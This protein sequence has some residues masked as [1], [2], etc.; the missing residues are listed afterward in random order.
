MIGDGRTAALV[1]REGSIDWLCLP[2]F[3]SDACCAALLGTARHGAWRIA[4]AGDFTSRRQY[5]DHTLVLCTEFASGSARVRL[6]DFMDVT[7][8]HPTVVR[9]LHGV[10]GTMRMRCIMAPRFDYG[11]VPPRIVPR[12]GAMLAVIGPDL[13][14]L[15]APVAFS[16]PEPGSVSAEFDIAAG[17]S[18]AFVLSYGLSHLP[19]PAAVEP[20]DALARTLKFWR[21]WAGQ[22]HFETAW[23]EPV[24][25]SLLTLKALVYRPTGGMV[26]AATASL[27]EVPAGTAN[28]DYRYSWLRDATFT[29]SALLNAGYH[30]EARSWR[31]W[32]LR[33]I[34]E[35]PENMRIMY[36]VD[37]SRRMKEWTVDWLPGF[38]G[39]APVRAGNDSAA[40]RQIDVVGELLDALD[41]MARAGVEPTAQALQAERLLVG[42]LE[43]TW[44]D[45]GHGL[46]ESR[47]RP[48]NY[49]YSMAMAWA[50]L[51]RFLRGQ[52]HDGTDPSRLRELHALRARIHDEVMENCWNRARGHFVDRFG[53]ERVDASLLL[54]P[55]VGFLPASDPR[56]AATIEAVA[57]DLEENG[58]VWRKPAG[59]DSSEG[60][61]IACSCWLA[62]CRSMQGR[63]EEAVAILERVLSLCNDVGLL[64][65]QYH[66]GL[67]CLTGNFPQALSHLGL[68]NTALGLSGPVLQR[69]GG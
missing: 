8:E 32:M 21:D 11:L 51:D 58:L 34:G 22:F 27:P 35:S 38:E 36:R 6:T 68:V 64:S 59:G 45:K 13:L 16:I 50:G 33:A 7:A 23:R 60:A 28:W 42:R 69:G 25:R 66:P 61:F 2:R 5:Q 37:G 48:E 15:R 19:P 3:D 40:Q 41:L 43:Q 52:R 14:V 31:D 63:R 30:D 65:E 4:P 1:S 46:W 9:L 44:Q 18:C 47:G 17:Q 54:L 49:T 26:A 12:D 24:L 55:L 62:D 10:Q 67:G 57:R 53:G 20:D 29:V 39:G 56:M